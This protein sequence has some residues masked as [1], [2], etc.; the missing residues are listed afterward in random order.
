[1]ITFP[2]RGRITRRSPR[3][4]GRVT[5][6]VKLETGEKDKGEEKIDLGS[7][8]RLNDNKATRTRSTPAAPIWTCR[9]TR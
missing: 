9:S 7:Y 1:M 6:L 4:R 2:S 8:N 3:F 5:G